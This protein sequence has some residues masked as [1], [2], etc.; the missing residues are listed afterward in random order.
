M[1]RTAAATSLLLLASSSGASAFV[2]GTTGRHLP[3]SASTRLQR[4]HCCPLRRGGGD[5]QRRRPCAWAYWTT[6]SLPRQTRDKTKEFRDRL[7]KGEGLDDMIEEAFAV[8]REAAWR[9][10][11]LRHYDVQLMGGLALHEGKLAEMATGEGKTLVATL[12]CYLNALAG[13]GTVLVVTANDYLARRDAETMGQVHRFLGLSVGLIQST[14]PEAQRKEAYSCDVT[15]ATNQELG[16]DYLRDHLTVTQDGTVQ[17]KDFFFCLVDEADSILIDEAR[18]PLIISR[19]VDAPAQKFATSQKIASVLEKG[20]HYTVSEKEQSVVLTDKG[21]DDCDRILGKSMFDPRDPW[22]PFIINS[23][24]AKEIFT[25]DKEYIVRDTEVLIVDT[26]SGRVLEGRRYSDGLHQSIE[27]KE[28]ITVSKQSQVMAQVTYQALFRSFPKLC[29]MTGT[30]MTDANELGTTYGLQ[31]VQ[32]RLFPDVVFRNREGANA[33]MLNEVERLHKDG[34]PVLI[35]TTNVGMSDQTAKT[36]NANPDL[37][38]RESEIVGQAGRLGVVTVATNMAGRGTDILLGGNPSVMARIRVRDALAAELLSDEDLAAVP[39]VGET[40][41]P[42]ELPEDAS[43]ALEKA[44]AACKG[45]SALFASDNDSIDA[46]ELLSREALEGLVSAAC[47]AGPVEGAGAVAV[48]EAATAVKKSFADALSEEK[49]KVLELGGLYVVGTARHES[50]RVDNQLRGRAGRQGDPGATRF[51]LSLDDDIFR[52]FGGD[53]VTKIMDSFRLSDDIPIENKQVSA[54]LD[55]VQIA[56]E[57]YFAGIRRTVFSFDEVMNDQRLALYRARDDVID[58][59][60]EELRE[61]ALEY[62]AKTCTEIVQGN[63]ASDGTPKAVLSDKLRQFFPLGDA[64]ALS[65]ESLTA[66]YSKGGKDGLLQHALDQAAAA[67]EKKLSDI[68]AVRAGLSSE[69]ARFLTL[70]QMDD[71][72]CQHLENM[73]LLKESVSMEVFRGRNPLEEFGAQGKEMFLDLLDNVRR[74]TVYSLQMYNPS[75]KTSAAAGADK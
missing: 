58:K 71:L 35:G 17:T 32:E 39:K 10:L 2:Q 37:V 61:L 25:R 34:R 51:F 72:W 8:V 21:Y 49:E 1:K 46:G 42:C 47:E 60:R 20:V 24:K 44:I 48:R 15:Y 31:V 53:Q 23:V 75:P 41:F 33:A 67:T 18:T 73:N 59:E 6:C 13:K 66:A 11:E 69:S 56:T 36:L 55:K 45:D 14:M 40:F 29:G 27:A 12:P 19:S 26:F 54:T 65:A 43:S 4:Q 63:S 30:A 28:G 62:S 5:H 22:A 64:S 70:T 50:R 7:S 16:F 3:S 74:N 52:V 68:E 38:E 9:V 57:D